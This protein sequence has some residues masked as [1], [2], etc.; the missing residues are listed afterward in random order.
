[1]SLKEGRA[2]SLL[3]SFD[4]RG[5]DLIGDGLDLI[6][7]FEPGNVLFAGTAHLRKLEYALIDKRAKVEEG[8]HRV[9]YRD[10]RTPRDRSICAAQLDR[11][12][13]QVRPVGIIVK[14]AQEEVQEATPK[15]AI[16]LTRILIE[17]L[18]P[19]QR[20]NGPVGKN[21]AHA[22][23]DALHKQLRRRIRPW[24][25]FLAQA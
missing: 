13:E 21:K 9:G 1:M 8:A 16:A 7:T 18:V 20:L 6:E 12:A 22:P 2:R 11:F 17:V 5:Q 19:G 15:L 25:R 24:F 3:G 10:V 4:K 14:R 23:Q